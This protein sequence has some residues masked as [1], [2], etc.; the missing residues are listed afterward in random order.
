MDNKT[1]LL[2][3]AKSSDVRIKK[4][5]HKEKTLK[6]VCTMLMKSVPV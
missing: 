1:L 6:E 3:F 2:Y 4:P 5:I